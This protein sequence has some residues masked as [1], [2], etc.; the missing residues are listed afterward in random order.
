MPPDFG[1]SGFQA[2]KARISNNKFDRLVEVVERLNEEIAEDESLGEGFRIGHSYFCT[3]LTVNDEWL[4]SVVE[5]ELIPL[6]KEYRISVKTL[7]LDCDFPDI[8]KRLDEI[9]ATVTGDDKAAVQI[10]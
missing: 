9:A 8:A 10:K 5:F 6:L 1:S 2:Y 3:N 7:D 4:R